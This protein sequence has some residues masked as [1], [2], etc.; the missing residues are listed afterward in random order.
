MFDATQN[1]VFVQDIPASVTLSLATNINQIWYKE[2]VGLIYFNDRQH[3][4][5]PFTDPSVY[6]TQINAWITAMATA[7]PALTLA[8][9]KVI[10]NKFVGAIY[11]VK[12]QAPVTV[13]TSLGTLQFEATDSAML[14]YTLQTGYQFVA[15]LNAIIAQLN[16][17]IAEGNAVLGAA[18]G[19]LIPIVNALIGNSGG[20]GLGKYEVLMDQYNLETFGL[21]GGQVQPNPPIRANLPGDAS[22]WGGSF[23]SGVGGISSASPALVSLGSTAAQSFTENDLIAIIAAVST[24][25]VVK[26]A[27]NNAK[28]AAVN[29]CGT[30]AAVVALDVTTG[31]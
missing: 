30:I 7:T 3:I 23:G 10:K 19:N 4:G 13:G 14:A 16:Q 29:A 25:V 18:N 28:Q 17:C 5:E 20:S 6:Q 31:W 15:N 22:A 11:D 2:G 26:Q 9:A 12:R 27:V 21:S 1:R 8:Q 24:Q